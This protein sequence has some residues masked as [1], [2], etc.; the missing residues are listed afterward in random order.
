MDTG[1]SSA[2]QVVRHT[3]LTTSPGKF[4]EQLASSSSSA[5]RTPSFPRAAAVVYGAG[6]LVGGDVCPQSAAGDVHSTAGVLWGWEC[7]VGW[8]AA[9]SALPGSA[10]MQQSCDTTGDDP[11]IVAL[12]TAA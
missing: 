9:M 3:G 5:H 6:P 1:S 8:V 12:L 2:S 4:P 10:G 11:A 7:C